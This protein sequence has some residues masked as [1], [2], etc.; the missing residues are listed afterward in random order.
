MTM[1]VGHVTTNRERFPVSREEYADMVRAA[2]EDP[3]FIGEVVS[4]F[5]DFMRQF[6]S[7]EFFTMAM[8]RFDNAAPK[9]GPLHL[10]C[11]RNWNREALEE[12]VDYPMYVMLSKAKL[13]K[14][15]GPPVRE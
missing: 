6:P 14:L 13:K 12:L 1:K 8:Q 10:V 7:D 9:Y 4:R 15:T 2:Q 11:N 5:S 3:E